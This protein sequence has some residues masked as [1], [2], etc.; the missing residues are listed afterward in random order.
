M[1]EE[2]DFDQAR[3]TIQR[4]AEIAE[5]F[6]FQAGVGG[7]ET[8][9]NLVSYLATHP[10]DIEPLLRFGI[11]ELPSDWHERGVLTWHAKDG[12]VTH[13][14]H[15]RRARVIKKLERGA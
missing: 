12:K 3:R 15:A 4:L 13:P 1:R 8:A 11:F 10:R 9:G 14:D 6:G 2:I 5:A 7:M